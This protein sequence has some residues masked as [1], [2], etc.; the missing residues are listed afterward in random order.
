MAMHRALDALGAFVRRVSVQQ[1]GG[2]S[3]REPQFYRQATF[4]ALDP[5]HAQA[6]RAHQ[7]ARREP[8]RDAAGD[9][10]PHAHGDG[11][12]AARALAAGAAGERA[13]DRRSR[14]LRRGAAA[15][16][17]A[18]PR[19]AGRAARL[20]RPRAHRAEGP[21]PACAAARSRRRCA[22]RWRCS[23]R[24]RDALR[25]DDA[26]RRDAR[27][28]AAR[29]GDFDEVRA[30]LKTT[31]VDEPPATL[32]DGGVI[33]PEREPEL[34]ECV[35]LRGDARS[36]IAALEDRERDAH[37]DQV[38]QGQVRVGIRLRDRSPQSAGRQRT[39]RLHAQ[40]D[41]GERRALRDAR[42][43]RARRRDR[44]GAS[45]PAAARAG[46]VRSGCVERDRRT[47]RRLLATADALAELDAYCSLAQVAGERGYVRPEFVDESVDRDRRRPA[48]R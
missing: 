40:A 12:A 18:A 29:V 35:A 37:R 4:V 2:A 6:P 8:A 44:V 7:S 47:G 11:L 24:S 42:A 10:R 36:R 3:L 46:A 45:A 5:E 22:A 9:D 48:S 31:L 1:N 38:A 30:E 39:G 15:R 23:I 17:C 43:A 41:A 26:A 34:A 32:G 13:G 28:V 16:R 21:F 14:R 20:L 25:E 27:A 33:R 19:A